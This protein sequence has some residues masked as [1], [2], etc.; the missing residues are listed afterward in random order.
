[1]R[2]YGAGFTLIELMVV[3]SLIGMLSSVVLAALNGA[4][5][6]G[7]DSAIKQSLD[8]AR[9]QAEIFYTNTHDSYLE[10][11]I[12]SV[13]GSIGPII[14]HA[15]KELSSSATVVYS[16]DYVYSA[17]GAP[18]SAVCKY[19]SSQWVAIVSLKNPTLPAGPSP[20]GGWCVD[21]NGNSLEV[22]KLL[23][24]QMACQ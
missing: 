19:N 8:N 7:A 18:Q 17:T 23:A 15:A 5:T 2:K 21:S 4:R 3:V 22:A 12:V 10:V 16:G 9:T 11:C 14:L 1:M 13:A 20:T 24:A 6:K